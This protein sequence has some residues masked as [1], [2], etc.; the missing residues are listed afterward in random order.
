MQAEATASGWTS[1][2]STRYS[3]VLFR[4]KLGRNGREVRRCYAIDFRDADGKRRR[5]RVEGGLEE[6]RRA[7]G[8][9]TG[10][11]QKPRRTNVTL[12]QMFEE[13]LEAPRRNG[14]LVDGSKLQYRSNFAKHVP[15]S[16]KGKKLSDLTED[17]VLRVLAGVRHLSPWT[18]AGVFKTVSGPLRLA[19]RRRLI[20]SNPAAN[21]LAEERP[22]KG[23]R[24]Q[25][26]LSPDEIAS[27]LTICALSVE[28]LA[29]ISLA[30]YSG[31]RQS[32][33]LGLRWGDVDWDKVAIA[34]QVDKK[35]RWTSRTKSKKRTVWIPPQVG[36]NLK[37]LWLKS[38]HK[39][40]DHFVF[41]ADENRPR[42]QEW[43]RKVWTKVRDEAGVSDRVRFHD[44]R[45]TFASILIGRGAS[46]VELAEQLGDS[47]QVALSTYA[48]LFDKAA[49][50]AKLRAILEASY[51]RDDV[52]A[53]GRPDSP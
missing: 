47:V 27:V 17:D 26:V 4:A 13:W 19:L 43:A 12:E 45:H 51:P 32:E 5:E 3:G 44:L 29:L 48:G 31:A 39:N 20:A 23:P 46:P 7:L 11:E 15:A 53:G 40:A 33:L 30:I 6:A 18:Q 50:E 9:I 10:S 36:T 24:R 8:K 1:W 16:V 34:G 14:G 49:S 21:L 38:D 41:A 52:G 28:Q 22:G 42:S 37:A 25:A 35:H 2:R